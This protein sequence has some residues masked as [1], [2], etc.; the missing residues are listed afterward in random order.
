MNEAA[1]NKGSLTAFARKSRDRFESLLKE[2]V[3]V[4]SVSSDPSK[5]TAILA[6]M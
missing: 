5:K 6:T 4:Q 1:M 3:E 2:F